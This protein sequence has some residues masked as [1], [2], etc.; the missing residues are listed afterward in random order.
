[1]LA[2]PPA[3]VS[4]ETRKTAG[5][6]LFPLPVL[7]NSLSIRRGGGFPAC[8]P[9][10]IVRRRGG[11]VDP[12]ATGGGLMNRTATLWPGLLLACPAPA[13]TPQQ[14]PHQ[15]F[16]EGDLKLESGEAIRDF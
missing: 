3:I 8:P 5:P 2:N 16:S 9:L 15:S 11:R 13:H 10:R 14:P 1:M 4:R 7:G 6:D 12:P